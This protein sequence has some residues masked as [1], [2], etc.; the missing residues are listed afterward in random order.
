MAV[1]RPRRGYLDRSPPGRRCPRH[2]VKATRTVRFRGDRLPVDRRGRCC[3]FAGV[4]PILGSSRDPGTASGVVA[5][6]RLSSARGL[7]S[8]ELAAGGRG[9]IEPIYSACSSSNVNSLDRPVSRSPL[10]SH[11]YDC[12][13]PSRSLENVSIMRVR[14]LFQIGSVGGIRSPT[15]NRGLVTGYFGSYI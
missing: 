14:A 5:T 1:F 13:F 8:L 15:A 6:C 12:D 3:R 11:M 10:A 4:D 9:S 7:R 2:P